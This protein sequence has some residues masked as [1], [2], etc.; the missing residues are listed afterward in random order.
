MPQRT[1]TGRHSQEPRL[2]TMTVGLMHR[3]RFLRV[4]CS[5][6]AVGSHAVL[7]HDEHRRCV[8]S[9][10]DIVANTNVLSM[11]YRPSMRSRLLHRVGA[12]VSGEGSR[13]QLESAHTTAS[14]DSSLPSNS[15]QQS[16]RSVEVT[17]LRLASCR[18][19]R[20]MTKSPSQTICEHPSLRRLTSTSLHLSVCHSH[21]SLKRLEQVGCPLLSVSAPLMTSCYFRSE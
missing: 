17:A 6:M 20:Q 11:R 12:E 5:G 2:D 19:R 9:V 18:R 21:A 7:G 10:M 3:K 4:D 13:A 1:T 8:A 15:Q 14:C 16:R